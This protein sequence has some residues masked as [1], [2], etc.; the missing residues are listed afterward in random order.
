MVHDKADEGVTRWIVSK[1]PVSNIACASFA[2]LSV[3][4]WVGR[5]GLSSAVG[6][7]SK[8]FVGAR[9]D[10]FLSHGR[11]LLLVCWWNMLLNELASSCLASVHDL[12]VVRSSRFNQTLVASETTQIET[13]LH[14]HTA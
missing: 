5:K 14:S 11:T 3:D 10:C 1:F 8:L 7:V 6:T 4:L 2:F 13:V 12:V 9:C